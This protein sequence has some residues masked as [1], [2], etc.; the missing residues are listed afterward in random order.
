[1]MHVETVSMMTKY[2]LVFIKLET[3][4]TKIS[5]ILKFRYIQEGGLRD[6]HTLCLFIF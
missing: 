2:Q 6:L 3:S 4:L 1:M 5:N